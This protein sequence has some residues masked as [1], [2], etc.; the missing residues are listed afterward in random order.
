M[1]SVESINRLRAILSFILIYA[2]CHIKSIYWKTHCAISSII[3]V[4]TR[5][6]INHFIDFYTVPYKAL[7]WFPHCAIS[8]IM[9]QNPYSFET[10]LQHWPLYPPP[11]CW[12]SKWRKQ[13]E[14]HIASCWD[15][16]GKHTQTWVHLAGKEKRELVASWV[17]THKPGCILLG[18]KKYWKSA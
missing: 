2:R 17:N 1:W 12:K 11:W 15:L 16:L 6:H 18:K 8:I 13:L 10:I 5:C 4:F 3:L 7:C 14:S 9:L